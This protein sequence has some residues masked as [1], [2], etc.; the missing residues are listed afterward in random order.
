MFSLR[1]DAFQAQKTAVQAIAMHMSAVGLA[2][3]GGNHREAEGKWRNL[4]W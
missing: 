3:S 2:E 1:K 4:I